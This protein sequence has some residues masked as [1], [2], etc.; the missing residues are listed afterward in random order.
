MNQ[1]IT[2]VFLCLTPPVRSR[3]WEH[4]ERNAAFYIPLLHQALGC[5]LALDTCEHRWCLV[6][7]LLIYRVT[8]RIGLR[9]EHIHL[10]SKDQCKTSCVFVAGDETDQ[11]IVLFSTTLESEIGGVPLGC[12]RVVMLCR[13]LHGERALGTRYKHYTALTPPTTEEETPGSHGADLVTLLK[14]PTTLTRDLT[15]F[16]AVY[17]NTKS[18]TACGGEQDFV[19]LTR[20]DFEEMRH[21]V[22]GMHDT[23]IIQPHAAAFNKSIGICDDSC[24]RRYRIREPN[25]TI[26]RAED[27]STA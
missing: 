24:I 13:H 20:V 15:Q 27:E 26:I 9:S 18:L 8:W 6:L 12:I 21:L 3:I 23:P 10:Y 5:D 2:H 22:G 11:T 1:E 17:Q 4:V 7:K 16:V 25:G 19:V 14:S